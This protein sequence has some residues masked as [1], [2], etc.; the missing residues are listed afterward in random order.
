MSK[1]ILI[2]DGTWLLKKN[3]KGKP[4]LKSSTG[5]LC[6]GVI[7]FMFDL[8]MVMNKLLP[9]RVVVAWDGFHSGKLRFDIYPPYKISRGKNFENEDRAIMTNGTG[10][11]EDMEKVEMLKQK[12]LTQNI[13]DE[14]FVR[15]VEADYIEADDLIAQYVL[16]SEEDDDTIYIYSRDKD[17]LQLISEKVFIIT[18]DSVWTL[19]RAEYEKKYNHT[20]D[21][22]LIFKCFEGDDGDDIEGV[23]G[24]TRNTLIKYFPNIAKEK[25]LYSRLVEECYEAKKDKKTGKRKV[26][27]KII[28]AEHVLYRN[29]RLMNLKKPFLTKEAKNMIE[30][31]KHGTLDETRD[32][33]SAISFFYKEG[34]ITYIGAEY[35]QEFLSPFYMIMSKEKEYSNKMKM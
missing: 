23:N 17:Y 6:G 35:Q 32:I 1:R 19:N 10:S 20:L 22:E 15:Q 16:R 21:N 4:T 7:G 29:A 11:P 9:D 34:L 14:L 24:I 33:S 26:Y 31:V 18:S 5:E 3:F 25:Y 8:K 12:I 28:Q 13:L 2:I 30:V 27:D